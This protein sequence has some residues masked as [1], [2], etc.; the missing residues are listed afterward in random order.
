MIQKAA[1][2]YQKK[3]ENRQQVVVGINEFLSSS[4]KVSRSTINPDLLHKQVERINEVKRNR[5]NSAVNQSLKRLRSVAE[6]TENIIPPLI[7]CVETYATVGEICDSMREVFGTQS[8]QI[9]GIPV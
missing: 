6:S 2:E 8:E 4:T 5:D 9:S 1:Y 3:I 7:E